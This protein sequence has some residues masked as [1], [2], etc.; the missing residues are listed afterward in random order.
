MELLS[1]QV[2]DPFP[3]RIDWEI[4]GFVLELEVNNGVRERA[5]ALFLGVLK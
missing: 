4:N 1:N 2:L 3:S 5:P